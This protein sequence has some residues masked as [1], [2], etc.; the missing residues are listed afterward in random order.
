MPMKI[1]ILKER[2]NKTL[3]RK[4][5]EFRVDHSGTTTPSRADI[6]AKIMAQ[7]NA[8]AAAV[9]IKKLDTKYGIGITDGTARI[10]A[11]PEQMKKI[12]LV[13]IL[14]RHEPK[15]KESAE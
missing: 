14:K 12:E 15:K 11:T 13:H 5:I 3:A 1:E 8:D 7:F 9:V 10:Y 2:E 6:H 4:E